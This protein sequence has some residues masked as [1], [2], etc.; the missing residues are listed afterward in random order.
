M[1]L[2]GTFLF[3]L[4]IFSVPL[5]AQIDTTLWYPLQDGNYWEYSD[6]IPPEVSMITKKVIGDTLFPNGKTYKKIQYTNNSGGSQQVTY[7]YERE[8]SGR[9]YT[10]PAGPV[11]D[12]SC[13]AG[14]NILYDFTLQDGAIWPYC[15]RS[16]SGIY[17]HRLRG[18]SSGRYVDIFNRMMESVSFSSIVIN[19]QD[20]TWF[21]T[22]QNDTKQT[23]RGAGVISFGYDAFSQ[24]TLTGA[25]INGTVY[26]TL[27]GVNSETALMPGNSLAL[28]PNP[29]NNATVLR[30]SVS[31]SGYA[32]VLIYD[33]LGREAMR[34]AGGY[35]SAGEYSVPVYT[36]QLAGGIYFAVLRA[37]GTPIA[38][39]MVL[40]K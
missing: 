36:Q 31:V 30:Y 40:L 39:K 12:S 7:E 8:E 23:A 17:T 16:L 15:Y 1:K 27:S 18:T 20:T 38:K 32:E 22:D 2:R 34:A 9:V 37:S 19:G 33:A 25:I 35:H 26:G 10:P 14:E 28:Y 5:S 6:N 29:F 24:Y 4:M 3:L 13:T 21:V 11:L